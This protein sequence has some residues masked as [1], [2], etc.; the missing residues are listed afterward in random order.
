[1]D[2]SNFSIGWTS[3]REILPNIEVCKY[4]IFNDIQHS[5]NTAIQK[6][7]QYIWSERIVEDFFLYFHL[8]KN[9]CDN[10]KMIIRNPLYL[11]YNQPEILSS[12]VYFITRYTDTYE[13]GHEHP[14]PEYSPV[15]L[16]SNYYFERE[17]IV[18]GIFLGTGDVGLHIT[19]AY[20]IYYNQSKLLLF[21]HNN[22]HY[23]M[24]NYKYYLPKIYDIIQNINTEKVNSETPLIRTIEGYNQG[25]MHALCTFVNGI[26]IMDSIGIQNNIDELI[27]GASDPYLIEKYYRNKYENINVIKGI[28]VDGFDCN[29]LYKGVLFKYGHFHVTNKFAAFVKSYINKV[30]PI[31]DI[32]QSEIEHIKNNFYPIFLINLRCFTCQIKD[33]D[34]IISEVVNKLKNIYPNS[35]FLIGG[36]IGDYNAEQINQLNSCIGIGMHGYSPA[37]NE[38]GNTFISIKN[39]VKHTDI[40]SILDLKINNILE[41]AKTAHFSIDMGASYNAVFT[42]L[43]NVQSLYFG[44]AWNYHNKITWYVSKENLKESIF[45]D[46]PNKI[47]FISNNIY[48]PITCEISSDTI[49]NIVV[50]Y[51][52]ENNLILR[53]RNDSIIE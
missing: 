16:I 52:K 44:T 5:W 30:M 11:E 37:L 53:N 20:I 10:K 8:I 3:M 40:K 31:N 26:Y 18:V 42:I 43:L 14:I 49:V 41:F 4:D 23:D 50:D 36:F 27:I 24:K 35:F 7:G 33:Q 2:I 22:E 25:L 39:K 12:D 32:Y 15:D 48:D 51:D 19:V 21:H 47:K 17:N 1:M 9:M 28:P 38:Y 45:I 6:Y 13:H 29:K 46:D 34:I